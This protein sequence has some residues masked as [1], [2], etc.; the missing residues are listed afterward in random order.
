M[1]AKRGHFNDWRQSHGRGVLRGNWE[2][3]G[4]DFLHCIYGIRY[5]LSAYYDVFI[6]M[7]IFEVTIA[8]TRTK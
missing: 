3:M 5:L 7:S 6:V 4:I 2:Y 8:L 1:K